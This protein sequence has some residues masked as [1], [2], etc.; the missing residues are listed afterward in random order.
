MRAQA[1]AA[2]LAPAFVVALGLAPWA[3]CQAG[4]ARYC[5]QTPTLSAAQQ[6]RLFRFAA[7]IK[8]TLEDSGARLAL[9]ARSGL[10]LSR[11]GVRYSH[12]G[13]SLQQGLDT[14]WSVRQ[15]YFDCD[16]SKPRLFDQGVSGFVL[17][18]N[19]P[20]AGYVSA[21]T[22]PEPEAAALERT[23]LDRALALQALGT[24]Y[25]ANAHAFS[26]NYQNCN[27][28][29]AEMLAGAWSPPPD[30]PIAPGIEARRL[31]AQRWLAQQG[32]QPSVFEVGFRPLMWFGRLIPH[33]HEDDHPPADLAEARFRVSMPASIEAFVQ[34]RV[35]GA[36]RLEFCQ[37]GNRIVI[38]RGWTPIAEGCVAGEQD[39]TITLE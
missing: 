28:W 21:V 27:Q 11:F 3:A 22:L 4:V 6:D 35:P 34:A 16:E 5:D 33:V 12:A 10:D 17:G 19:D 36:Q 32:Y 30:A 31:Q 15:L 29:V 2:A 1:R 37:A 23:V 18:L 38:R 39:T 25:S 14:A 20:A 9:V 13:V 8:Q 26:V 24:R 7:V